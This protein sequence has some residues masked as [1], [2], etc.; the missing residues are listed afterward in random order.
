M[1]FDTIEYLK[2]G[3]T[4]QREAYRVLTEHKVLAKLEPFTPIL[5]GTIPINIDIETS[6]LDIVCYWTNKQAFSAVVRDRF[7]SEQAF[8]LREPSTPER[9]VVVA[10]FRLDEFDIEIFGQNIPVKQQMGYRHMLIEHNLLLEHGETFREEIIA[11]KRKGYKTEPAFGLLL[12]LQ[13]DP[14]VELLAFEND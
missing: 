9:D 6:D 5:V 14:Y 2:E 11:L 4:R 12:G 13:G 3:T 8:R 10:N 7:G 1:N